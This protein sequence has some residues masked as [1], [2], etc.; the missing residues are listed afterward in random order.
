[1]LDIMAVEKTDGRACV[2]TYFPVESLNV[3]AYLE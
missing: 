3:Y 2:S 1:M